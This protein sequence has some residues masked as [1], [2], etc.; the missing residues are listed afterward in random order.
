MD[1]FETIRERRMLPRVSDEP[2]SRH[3]IEELLDLAVRAPVHHRTD[4]WR[5]YVL[6]GDGRDRL[7]NAIA[8]EAIENGADEARAR[9]DARKKVE[10]APVI[11]V[12][13]VVPS[14]DPKVVEAEEFA[15][16]AMAMQNFLLGAYAKGLGAMLRTGPAAYH[17]SIR[18]HLELA[19]DES[20]VGT[21][22]L[23]TP[24]GDRETTERIPSGERTIWL[25]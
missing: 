4:P 16:V 14:D 25:S 7:A 15:S 23:G 8:D 24:V 10:R 13:T 3:D 2:P 17:R 12:F 6:S 5:F 9:E 21:V 20:V 1:V 19:P 18:E 11:V 22:Y